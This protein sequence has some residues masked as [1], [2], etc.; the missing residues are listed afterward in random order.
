MPFQAS[1]TFANARCA[2]GPRRRARLAGALRRRPRLAAEARAAGLAEAKIDR[3]QY[4]DARAL[5]RR[6]LMV[7]P[8][9]GRLLD[10]YERADVKQAPKQL[11][12]DIK[13]LFD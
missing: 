6:G 7:A 2:A 8:D 9:D 10:L 1:F 11:V 12:D 3:Y 4:R 13:R 5:A